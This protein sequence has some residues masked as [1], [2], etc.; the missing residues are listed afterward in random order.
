MRRHENRAPASPDTGVGAGTAVNAQAVRCFPNHGRDARATRRAF[1]LVEVMMVLFCLAIAGYLAL[2]ELFNDSTKLAQAA[3]MFVAD[4]EFA[5]SESLAHGDDP[6][7]IVFDPAN[8]LYSLTARSNTAI[9]LT[10]PVD[11]T[12]YTTRYGSGRAFALN[13]VTINSLSVGGDNQLGFGSL[14]EL[15]QTSAATIQLGY[16]THTVTITIDPTSG[17]ASVGMIE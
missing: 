16:R 8:N 4:L 11:Q 3:T 14:G 9:V 6:R 10:N 5:Q 7:V 1:T 15:D 17:S 13:N 12:P 2:P